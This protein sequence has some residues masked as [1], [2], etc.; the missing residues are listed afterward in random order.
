MLRFP[1]KKIRKQFKLLLLL[2]LLTSAVWF[3]YL[4]INQGKTIKLHFNYGKALVVLTVGQLYLGQNHSGGKI[5]TGTTL[6]KISP[7]RPPSDPAVSLHFYSQCL[8]KQKREVLNDGIC[9]FAARPANGRCVWCWWGG[10][11]GRA[12]GEGGKGGRRRTPFSRNRWDMQQD[13][14]GEDV[15]VT[16]NKPRPSSRSNNQ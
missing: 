13:A 2:V 9:S 3:T 8:A 10:V 16:H 5:V 11:G 1:V 4:H 15:A 12:F 7:L 6:A 14:S